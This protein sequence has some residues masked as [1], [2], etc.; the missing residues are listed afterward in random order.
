VGEVL[1]N[2]AN[3]ICVAVSELFKLEKKVDAGQIVLTQAARDSAWSTVTDGVKCFSPAGYY[4]SL[5]DGSRTRLF[6]FEPPENE[7]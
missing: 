7:T 4:E 2:D 6:A 5:V 1:L 3:P